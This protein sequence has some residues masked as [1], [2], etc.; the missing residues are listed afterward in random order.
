M[1]KHEDE[2]LGNTFEDCAQAKEANVPDSEKTSP[3]SGSRTGV[4]LSGPD[5]VWEARLEGR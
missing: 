4:R 2:I 3:R 1:F 5:R